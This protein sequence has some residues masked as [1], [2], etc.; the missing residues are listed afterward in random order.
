MN[1]NNLVGFMNV[2]NKCTANKF[3]RPNKLLQN[4]LSLSIEFIMHKCEVNMIE[5]YSRSKNIVEEVRK[6]TNCGASLSRF[7]N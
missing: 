1:R 5:S 4:H 3:I 6:R 7:L 2:L